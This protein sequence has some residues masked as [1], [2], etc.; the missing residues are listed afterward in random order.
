[1]QANP[2]HFVALLVLSTCCLSAIAADRTAPQTRTPTTEERQSFEAFYAGAHPGEKPART[3]FEVQREARSRGWAI[4]A[5]AEAAPHRGQG[6]LC[7]THRTRYVLSGAGRQATWQET[8]V[9]YYAWLDR[10]AC[11]PVAEPVRLLQRVPDA[12]LEGVLLYQKP[13][14]ARARLLLAQGRLSVT[15]IALD[16]GYAHAANFSTA[17][18]RRFG[19]SPSAAGRE[20][21][22]PH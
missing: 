1:M 21:A 22:R 17:F 12:E 18:K 9:E 5:T 3:L 19:M 14:L 8:G 11:R 16:V 20:A 4:G 13:L 6:A 15:Q 2:L 10:G 7:R